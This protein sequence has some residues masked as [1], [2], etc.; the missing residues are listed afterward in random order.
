VTEWLLLYLLKYEYI[1]EHIF[2]ELNRV[3]GNRKVTLAD[4]AHLHYI[5]AFVEE[6]MR[7]CPAMQ[8]SVPH[9][10]SKDTHL[11][12]YVI[13]KGTTI[14]QCNYGI[15]FDSKNFDNPEDF[16]PSRFLDGEGKFV[17]NEYG[18]FFGIGQRRCVG[19]A[20][21]RAELFLIL[22]NV[23]LTYKMSPCPNETLPGLDSFEPIIPGSVK[24]FSFIL[25]ER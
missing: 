19:E 3:V 14:F 8:L 12:G 1:Q 13:P 20:L 16:R 4:K 11:G 7:H 21:A 23:I 25:E 9:A 10:T 15:N 24:P 22:T 17:P 2:D 6:V 5:H 18:S